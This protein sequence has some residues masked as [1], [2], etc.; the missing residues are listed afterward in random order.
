MIFYTLIGLVLFVSSCTNITTSKDFNENYQFQNGD[1]YSVRV[2]IDGVAILESSDKSI[3]KNI[4]KELNTQKR[5]LAQEME[6][7]NPP[8]GVI[9]LIGEE[10]VEVSFFKETGRTLYGPYYIHTDFIFN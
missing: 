5:E 10:E 8:E 2:T 9:T 6:F 1:Y 7:E 4:I 3:I